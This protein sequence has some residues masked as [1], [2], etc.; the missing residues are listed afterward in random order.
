MSDLKDKDDKNACVLKPE[1]IAERLDVPATR[2]GVYA[3]TF[4]EILKDHMELTPGGHRRFSSQGFKLLFEIHQLIKIDG[5]SYAQAKEEMLRR[6]KSEESLN[7][8]LAPYELVKQISAMSD[9][10]KQ[11]YNTLIAMQEENV[12][13]REQLTEFMSQ[14]QY[15]RQVTNNKVQELTHKIDE[16]NGK[17]ENQ[18][19]WA[20][21]TLNMLELRGKPG[22]F[23]KLFGVRNEE[24]ERRLTEYCKSIIKNDRLEKTRVNQI[25]AT[26]IDSENE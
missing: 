4:E 15:E 19:D 3:R 12:R 1:D 16:L 13:L 9:I 8:E 23:A 2:I 20:T 6:I 25:S 24:E 21:I 5:F 14:Q 11:F 17:L 10:D 22:F 7:N 26:S 18:V